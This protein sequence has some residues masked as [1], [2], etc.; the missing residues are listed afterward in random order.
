MPPRCGLPEM[1]ILQIANLHRPPEPTVMRGG[2]ADPAT[3][4]AGRLRSICAEL[5]ASAID[6]P[7]GWSP[8]DTSGSCSATNRLP[9]PQTGYCGLPPTPNIQRR[10]FDTL[11]INITGSFLRIFCADVNDTGGSIL[12]AD[13]HPKPIANAM[14]RCALPRRQRP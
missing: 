4:P 1:A 8:S 10:I 2:G 12:N 6:S 11:S 5:V 3:N 9:V 13:L 7:V 14:R